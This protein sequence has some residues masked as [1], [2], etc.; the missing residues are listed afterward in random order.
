M[1]QTNVTITTSDNQDVIWNA[2][3]RQAVNSQVNNLRK[4]IYRAACEGKM[5]LVSS[6]KKL[7]LKSKSNKLHAMRRITQINKGRNTSSVN[8]IVVNTDK[9]RSLLLKKLACKDIKSIKP[10]K[11]VYIPKGNGKTRPLGLPTILDRC[12]QAIVKSAL[13]PY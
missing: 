5:K 4:R 9:N 13:K 12:R 1:L 8:K 3:N 10:I 7:M 6:L 11:R 2:I